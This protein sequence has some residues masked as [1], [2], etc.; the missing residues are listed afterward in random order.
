MSTPSPIRTP[1]T[2]KAAQQLL[3][4]YADVTG[5]IDLIEAAR[6]EAIA[7]INGD[8]D[9]ELS[10]LLTEQSAIA[11]KLEIWWRAAGHALTEGKRKSI[12]L[13]GC[14]IGSRSGRVSLGIA[15][16]EKEIVKALQ[17]RQWGKDMLRTTVS[18]DKA[19]VLKS[20]DGVYAKDLRGI[21]FSKKEPGETVYIER[22]AQA[23]TLATVSAG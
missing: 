4:R 13:G 7:G 6:T 1:K 2:T 12:E 16:D 22:T 21:G 23:G 18:I 8:R 19:A 14:V 3:E 15:G 5:Q 9:A 10:P 11:G 17:R 20:L